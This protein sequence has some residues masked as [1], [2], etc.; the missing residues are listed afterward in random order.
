MKK[1]DNRELVCSYFSSSLAS[2]KE[3]IKTTSTLGLFF[4]TIS[5]ILRFE[6]SHGI[7]QSVRASSQGVCRAERNWFEP[8]PY[9]ILFIS[10]V[11][12][13]MYQFTISLYLFVLRTSQKPNATGRM[14]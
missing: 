11:Y 14:T 12:V 9:P 13:L 1:S 4:N 7:A 8:R 6:R 10:S 3:V 5:K 2:F